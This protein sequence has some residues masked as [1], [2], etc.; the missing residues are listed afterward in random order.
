MERGTMITIAEVAV[1]VVLLLLD[2]PSTARILVGI[3]LVLHLGWSAVT[4]LPIGRV[5]GPP[6]GVG[7]RRRK[8]LLRYQVVAFL[9]YVQKVESL[10]EERNGS[11]KPRRSVERELE[12][13]EHRLK[14]IAGDIVKV[15]GRTGV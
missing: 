10:V 12:A 14:E 13:A 15:A 6:P 1:L 7:E 8:H 3:P 9:D 5:P 2:A 4:S 11:T